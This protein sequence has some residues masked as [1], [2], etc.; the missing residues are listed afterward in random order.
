MRYEYELHRDR[1]IIEGKRLSGPHADAAH[2][3]S[4]PT[5]HPCSRVM[6]SS[7]HAIRSTSQ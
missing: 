4:I 2:Y 1:K 3:F 7:M 6:V 5:P